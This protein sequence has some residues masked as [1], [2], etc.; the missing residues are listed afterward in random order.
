MAILFRGTAMRRMSNWPIIRTVYSSWNSVSSRRDSTCLLC[1]LIPVARSA[2]ANTK[3][4]KQWQHCS[5]VK[6][7][8]FFQIPPFLTL[9]TISSSMHYYF[10]QPFLY[11]CAI[12]K[13]SKFGFRFW[14]F[15]FVLLTIYIR[16]TSRNLISYFIWNLKLFKMWHPELVF[17][18]L[19]WG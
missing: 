18:K 6:S 8:F 14:A 2:K 10:W 19:K 9:L 16:Q 3:N 1:F 7:N 11:G 15:V 4:M 5:Y 12:Q 17:G 13:C